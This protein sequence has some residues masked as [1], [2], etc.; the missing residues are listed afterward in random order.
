MHGGDR[1]GNPVIATPGPVIEEL[2]I[3]SPTAA[4]GVETPGNPETG[5]STPAPVDR[6]L[7]QPSPD[8]DAHTWELGLIR[9]NAW[10]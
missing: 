8:A 7:M 5:P 1:P 3:S 9:E 10:L 6:P 2:Q 4:A